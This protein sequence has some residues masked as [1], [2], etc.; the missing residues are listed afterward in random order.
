[1]AKAKTRRLAVDVVNQLGALWSPDFDA[2][3]SGQLDAASVRCAL[4]Q[5]APCDCPPFGTPAYI[6]LINQR[7]GR[8][9]AA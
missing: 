1:M 3:A 9:P 2:Y 7:H 8:G 5:Q 6:A 4:C